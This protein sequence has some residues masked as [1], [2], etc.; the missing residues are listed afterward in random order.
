M[1]SSSLRR[2]C[3]VLPMDVDEA[4]PPAS[5]DSEATSR[6]SRVTSTLEGY[7]RATAGHLLSCF[8]RYRPCCRGGADRCHDS[9]GMAFED[10]AGVVDE[11]V[12]GRKLAGA[13]G[14]GPRIFSYSEL[15]IGT[16]GFSHGEV[17]GSGGFGRV[18]RAVLPS[19]GTTVAVKCVADSTGRFDKSFLAELAA[20]AR[21]RHRNLVRL[22]GWCVRAGEELMLVYDYMPNRSLDRL[23]FAPPAKAKA[24][25]PALSWDRR[26]RIVA[27][28][29]AALFYLHEQ[30]DT[31]IIHRDVKTSNVMLDSEY[32]ARLGDFGLA[33]WLEHAVSADDAHVEVSPSP[34]SLRL[35]SSSPAASA[36]YQFRLMDTSRI[37]GTIGYLPPESFQRRATG[38]TAKSD[39]FSFGI[40]LLEVAT[41]RRAVDLA[42]P[43]DQIFMLDWVRRLSD[44]GKLLD[45]AD[46]KLP[47]SGAGALFD[48]VGRV[49]HLGLLC[50]LHDPRARPTMRWVVENL[51]DGCSGGELPRL[52]SFVAL[53]KYISLTTSSASDSGATT[54]TTDRSTATTSLSNPVYATAAADTIYHTAEDGSRAGSRSAGSG[55]RSS[56]RLSPVAAIPHVDMPREIP[57]KEIV[58]ITN[59]FSESQVVAELDFGTGYEGF[60]DTGHGRVHVL[61]KRLGMKTCPA[62]R[63]RFARELCNLAKLRHR[64]LVQLRGWCTDH[65]EMLVVYDYAP[66]SLL[67][68]Y[69]LQRRHGGAAVLPWRQRY[70]IV[71]A[72]AS[73]ILYLHEEW[74]EQVIHRNITSSAVFLDPDMNPRLG[75]FALAEF[76]SRNEHG[77]HHVVVTASSAKGIFGYMSPE[78]MDTGEAT[79]MADVYSFGV[80]VLEVVTGTMA[81]DGRL[82]EVLLVRKVQLFEQLNRPVEAMAD[83]RLDGRF[84]RRELVRMARLGMACTRSDPAAR[85]SMRKI[86]SILDGNDEVLDK[87]EQRKESTEDWQRRNATNLALVRRFQALGIH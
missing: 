2:L 11:G 10:I 69:L 37:G 64:N 27:G 86:V 77:G 6:R 56:S 87:F 35:S 55:R 71:R 17:L 80:V 26:R 9:S 3:F 74:D 51:S 38:G 15:Y 12:A 60:L 42:Y 30:L 67:S 40:V 72:L 47:D 59:D 78:Y 23:L 83:Q 66:G 61:V 22:R 70:S 7:A 63:V 8:R 62:L 19:D 53:P 29:A 4:I 44:E 39:V 68:H 48:D 79:T 41:G 76:L 54:V 43:D 65:G 45:A 73:A 24:P 31:Q 50:S 18:Y 49:M 81:V 58:A 25:V 28:L 16:R 32:N 21:L 14:G 82:P 57:Y 52:P 13:A 75:S 5:S 85:P 1:S 34:T 46:A 33:R 36:N 20:V 84:D